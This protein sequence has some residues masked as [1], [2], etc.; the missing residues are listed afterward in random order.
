MSLQTKHVSTKKKICNSLHRGAT[1]EEHAT[2]YD[3]PVVTTAFVV[4]TCKRDELSGQRPIQVAVFH[5]FI[6]F[7]F[8][9]VEPF[10]VE[11]A[12]QQALRQTFGA[13]LHSQLVR[14]QVVVPLGRGVGC[15][16]INPS[17]IELSV[18]Q[19]ES[20]VKKGRKQNCFS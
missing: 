5:L 9:N 14:T 15:N 17:I 12:V 11:P 20:E 13:V 2:C 19:H 8:H 10:E 6:V 18:C 16:Q 3:V 4:R 1:R 7:V